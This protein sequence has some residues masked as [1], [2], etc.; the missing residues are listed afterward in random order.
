M[1]LEN[2]TLLENIL[3]GMGV[4]VGVRVQFVRFEEGTG[5]WKSMADAGL[6]VLY[7]LLLRCG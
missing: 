2:E 7:R 5:G 6:A 3:E 4:V 1:V